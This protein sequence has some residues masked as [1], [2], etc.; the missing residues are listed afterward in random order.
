MSSAVQTS[1][2]I[3]GTS[4]QPHIDATY[5]LEMMR[6]I[7]PVIDKLAAHVLKGAQSSY[8][9]AAPAQIMEIQQAVAEGRAALKARIPEQMLSEGGDHIYFVSTTQ[10][11]QGTWIKDTY[12]L[13]ADIED[14]I[15]LGYR[16]Q[17]DPVS[18][19]NELLSDDSAKALSLPRLMRAF[20]KASFFTSL[21][22]NSAGHRSE[23][24]ITTDFSARQL[25]RYLSNNTNGV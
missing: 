5:A 2:S 15:R 19:C 20:A 1:S 24:G 18:L 21:H 25:S 4:R 3:G 23:L 8:P 12:A 17:Q 10:R 11:P 14:R 7:S 16:N 9:I 6:A 22:L 13:L